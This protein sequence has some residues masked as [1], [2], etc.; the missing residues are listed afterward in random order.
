MDPPNMQ[1]FYRGELNKYHQTGT[2]SQPP[3]YSDV[4]QQNGV[5]QSSV[6]VSLA[7]TLQL[8][9]DEGSLE[10]SKNSA[11]ESAAKVV[12]NKIQE[13]IRAQG[14]GKSIML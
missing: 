12:C 10:N 14:R 4:Q 7:D 6:T 5:F 13:A 11:R 1:G 9:V 3:A 2:I 8:I